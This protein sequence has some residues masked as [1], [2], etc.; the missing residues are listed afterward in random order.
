MGGCGKTAV[1]RELSR[2]VLASG[3]QAWWINA[4]T[5]ESVDEGM[6]A[7]AVTLGAA[8]A[9]VRAGSLLE[10]V[11]KLLAASDRPWLLVFDNAD[12]PDRSLAAPGGQVADGN[13]VDSDQ[14]EPLRRR[15]LRRFA[16]RPVR[17]GL[18]GAGAGTGSRSCRGRR[19]R[20]GAGRARAGVSRLRA[21]QA[22]LLP[23]DVPARAVRVTQGPIGPEPATPGPGSSARL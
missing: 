1:A 14:F 4:T 18:R 2:R 12:D 15:Q 9:S 13:G 5:A 23:S 10:I 3:V 11:L 8:P 16:G 17:S 19:T 7:L 6:R 22:G 21:G 20:A